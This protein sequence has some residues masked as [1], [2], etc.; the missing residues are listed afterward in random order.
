[1]YSTNLQKQYMEFRWK[2]TKHRLYGSKGSRPKKKE[3]QHE[4]DPD[5]HQNKRDKSRA[6]TSHQHP[7]KIENQ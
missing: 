3:S 4:K 5:H 7:T 6:H 1:M 2:G